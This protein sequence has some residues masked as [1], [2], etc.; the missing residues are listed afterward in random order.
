MS[1]EAYKYA[2]SVN[3]DKYRQI[4]EELRLILDQM[5]SEILEGKVVPKHSDLAALKKSIK[6]LED[7][8]QRLEFQA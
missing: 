1:D 2:A 5:I 6:M 7:F 4:G 3:H 8:F